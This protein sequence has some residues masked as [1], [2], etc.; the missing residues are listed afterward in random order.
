[1]A[2]SASAS[3]SQDSTSVYRRSG[4]YSL[5]THANPLAEHA[6]VRLGCG[7]WTQI[8]IL[9]ALEHRGSGGRNREFSWIRHGAAQKHY[10]TSFAIPA[11]LVP[12]KGLSYSGKREI[13]GPVA[14]RTITSEHA[15]DNQGPRL[16]HR[17]GSRPLHNHD[18]GFQTFQPS[19]ASAS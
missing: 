4:P 17:N 1:M 18:S 7:R 12:R 3:S 19:G 16:S 6:R 9:F 14:H 2:A 15:E 5:A 8:V 11:E 13:D 10:Q